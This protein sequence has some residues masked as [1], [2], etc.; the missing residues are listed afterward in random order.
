MVEPLLDDGHEMNS[1]RYDEEK[2]GNTSKLP[3]L[4]LSS[5]E[6]FY[7]LKIKQTFNITT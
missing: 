3:A 5:N 4:I 1:L 6:E 7:R 2:A